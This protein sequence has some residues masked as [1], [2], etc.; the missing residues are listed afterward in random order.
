MEG[1]L[2]TG[3]TLSSVREGTFK[4]YKINLY[5]SVHLTL[6]KKFIS[7]DLF[8][9]VMYFSLQV[10]TILWRDFAEKQEDR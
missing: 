8:L 2:S 5:L 4:L 7:L 1:L 9:F 3:L 6:H 10:Q